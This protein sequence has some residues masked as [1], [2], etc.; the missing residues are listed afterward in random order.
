MSKL[1][2][3]LDTCA[4]VFGDPMC[5]DSDAVAKRIFDFSISHPSIPDYIRKDSVLYAVADFN[6]NT[7]EIIPFV[8]VVIARG[9]NVVVREVISNEE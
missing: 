9:C 2:C 1:Y 8:P 5:C 6:R 7:A 4:G 3:V